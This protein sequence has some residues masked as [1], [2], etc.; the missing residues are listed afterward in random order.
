MSSKEKLVIQPIEEEVRQ[1][2]LIEKLPDMLEF[3]QYKWEHLGTPTPKQSINCTPPNLKNKKIYEDEDKLIFK[4]SNGKKI[5]LDTLN[6]SLEEA[7]NGLYLDINAET[8]FEEMSPKK[9]VSKGWG[10]KT[11]FL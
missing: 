7:L 9:I 1:G 10:R 4:R 2:F 3:M 11:V 6:I 8:P 5:T